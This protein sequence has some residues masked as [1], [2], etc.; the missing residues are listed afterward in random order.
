MA[1][2]YDFTIGAGEA[3]L[4]LDQ[5]LSRRLPEFI[6]RTLVQRAIRSGLVTIN[7]FAAKVSYKLRSG[8]S[9]HALI[10][11]LPPKPEGLVMVAQSIALSIAYEDEHLLVVNKPAGLVTH[12]A[13]GHWDGTLV[14]AVLWH[15]QETGPKSEA[16]EPLARAGIVHRLDKDTSGLLMIA[17]TPQ[18]LLVV[19]R[20]MKARA[21]RRS[22]L[23]VVEGSLPMDSGTIDAS[24]A[25]HEV[26]RKR[27]TVRHLGGRRA[28]TRYAVLRRFSRKTAGVFPEAL[29][30]CSLVRLE[31]DTGRTHQIRVHMAHL[32]YPVLGDSVYGNRAATFWESHGIRRQ[33]LHAYQLILRHPATGFPLKLQAPP[34]AD[35]L[36]WCGPDIPL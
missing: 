29:L 25:R 27:M 32:G 6:S 35:F 14:N 10:E 36:P 11:E 26:H 20:Q 19:S 31:L 28:V 34:P 12:P 17:K 3:G 15:L 2:A 30:P 33:L 21:I 16:G 23:A 13:P 4:R 8:D 5:F 22:Y 1:R 24:I 9:V 7:G 18:A